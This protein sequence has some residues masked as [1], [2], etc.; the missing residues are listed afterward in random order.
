MK[1][2]NINQFTR[3]W[4]VGD[5][6]PNIIRTKDFEF[7]VR[8]YKKGEIEKKHIHKIANE[9]TVIMDGIFLMNNE[10]Y[11]KGD[12]I[13]LLPGDVT[14]FECLKNGSTAVVK[15]PS[16]IGDKYIL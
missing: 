6:T 14:D 11:I 5:F 12:I 1:K 3:G 10:K 16:V 13:H 2:Y 15:T 9:I 8:F 7:M 4:L